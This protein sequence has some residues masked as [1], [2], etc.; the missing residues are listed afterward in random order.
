[1]QPRTWT[2]KSAT[3][4]SKTYQ[5]VMVNPASWECSCP[6][7]QLRHRECKHIKGIQK[8][9]AKKA[10]KQTT[11]SQPTADE[12]QGAEVPSDNRGPG[13]ERDSVPSGELRRSDSVDGNP[14]DLHPGTQLN[15]SVGHDGQSSSDAETS[16]GTP[17]AVTDVSGSVEGSDTPT[18][19][20]NSGVRDEN[21]AREQLRLKREAQ[22]K[23]YEDW[24]LRE[25]KF[26]A[27]LHQKL[28]ALRLQYK[29]ETDK[30]KRKTITLMSGP[31][32]TAI[33]MANRKD[34]EAKPDFDISLIDTPVE[35]LDDESVTQLEEI[36][37]AL[38]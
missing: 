29:N 30:E 37:K 9:Y 31:L 21:D 18:P 23:Q 38:F 1:M 20:G 26:S 11:Q 10:N 17:N 27:E 4:A 12:R 25:T 22:L 34:W 24:Q 7:S 28:A 14:A 35:H 5:V 3:D 33:R 19:T 13:E 2:V 36:Q 16:V 8:A 32:K 15:G 6:D